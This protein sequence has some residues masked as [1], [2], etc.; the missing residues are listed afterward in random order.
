MHCIALCSKGS[1]AVP[2]S[3]GLPAVSRQVYPGLFKG[4]LTPCSRLHRTFKKFHGRPY[5]RMY[6]NSSQVTSTALCL[7]SSRSLSSTFAERPKGSK[8]SVGIHGLRS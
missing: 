6:A 1:D 4:L 5:S 3:F 8:K 2:S 7:D